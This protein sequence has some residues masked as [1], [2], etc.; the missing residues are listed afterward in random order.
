MRLVHSFSAVRCTPETLPVHVYTFT[1][2]AVYAK[3]NGFEIVLHTDKVGAHYLQHAPYDEIIVD[4]GTPPDDKRIF[5]WCK[6]VA[7]ANEPVDSIHIDGD[8][9]I[10]KPMQDLLTLK[11]EDILCQNLEKVGIF[12]YQE[13]CW[14]KESYVWRDC[15]YPHWMPRKFNEMY[16]CGIIAFKDKKIRDEYYKLYHDMMA[17]FKINGKSLDCVPELVSEQKLLY[18]FAK[19]KNLKVKCLLDLYELNASA[20]KIGYQHLLGAAKHKSLD[21]TKEVLL[22]TNLYIYNKTGKVLSDM[23]ALKQGCE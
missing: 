22:K 10:K 13:S 11:D 8:V 14:D 3:Q 17:D 18:D 1:L 9:F 23:S 5:A 20:N 7:M 15:R 21:K 12:P 4:L 16:N 2:S 19:H 6:F